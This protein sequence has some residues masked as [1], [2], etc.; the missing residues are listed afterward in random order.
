MATA[1]YYDFDDM[2]TGP[3]PSTLEGKELLDRVYNQGK[4]ET[5]DEKANVFFHVTTRHAEEMGAPDFADDELDEEF[6]Y[7]FERETQEHFARDI[8]GATIVSGDKDLFEIALEHIG[9]IK[10]VKFSAEGHEGQDLNIVE[11]AAIEEGRSHVQ[12]EMVAAV[13]TAARAAYGSDAAEKMREDAISNFGKKPEKQETQRPSLGE[14]K[15]AGKELFPEEK[16][17]MANQIGAM[18]S[19]GQR[20]PPKAKPLFSRGSSANSSKGDVETSSTGRITGGGRFS[21]PPSPEAVAQARQE[22]P[23]RARSSGRSM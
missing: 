8:L 12:P 11:F 17:A 9:D 3:A 6:E 23:P 13:M 22:P 2:R 1:K 16:Q 21:S 19:E 14:Q 20:D 18:L 4:F 15:I 5:K 10:D 7:A